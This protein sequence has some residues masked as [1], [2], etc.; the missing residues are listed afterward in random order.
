MPRLRLTLLLV[1]ALARPAIGQGPVFLT[2]PNT[3]PRSTLAP[4][5][6]YVHKGDEQD[7]NLGANFG[8]RSFLTLGL[9]A[10]EISD[11]GGPYQFARLQAQLKF[12]PYQKV[13]E[14]RRTILGFAGGVS[15]P[16]GDVVSQVA[17][18]NGLTRLSTAVTFA[19]AGHRSIWI[20][21]LQYTVDAHD[22][23]DR[24]TGTAGAAVGWRP[25]PAP[26]GVTGGPGLTFFGEAL[27]HYETDH[28]GWVALAPGFVL[29]K[30]EAQIKGGAR[31][32][33]RRWNATSATMLYLGTSVFVRTAK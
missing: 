30:G 18:I 27:A 8:V 16:L 22:T 3:V 25:K 12:R 11:G 9:G 24:G 33:F 5:L 7:L 20:A 21:G 17:R 19:H 4:T 13:V 10:T 14:G 32:P 6:S 28:S 31:V 1:F 2:P 29:R 23:A 26:P 15:V